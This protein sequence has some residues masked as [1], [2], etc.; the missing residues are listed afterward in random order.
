MTEGAHPFVVSRGEL[1]PVHRRGAW[2]A[3][4]LALQVT[5][6]AIPA[7]AA[8]NRVN[9][10]NAIGAVTHYTFRLI[11]HELLAVVAQGASDPSSASIDG[12]FDWPFGEG[13]RRRRR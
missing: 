3:S 7:L 9:H 8:L 5:G 4:G 10:D 6:V 13:R 1:A 2:V 12:L 11:L